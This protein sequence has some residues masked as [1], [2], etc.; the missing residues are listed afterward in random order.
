MT[1]K[2]TKRPARPPRPRKVYTEDQMEE[3]KVLAGRAADHAARA[4]LGKQR[5]DDVV[6][7]LAHQVLG[8]QIPMEFCATAA[9]ITS[10][11]VFT[12]TMQMSD[13]NKLAVAALASLP[14]HAIISSRSLDVDEIVRA[15]LTAGKIGT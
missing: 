1:T 10:S 12:F 13:L 14:A 6:R 15:T 7:N 11:G 5:Q 4:V 8:S 2:K 3:A 9:Q